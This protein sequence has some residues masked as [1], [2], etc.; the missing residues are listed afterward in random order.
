MDFHHKQITGFLKTKTNLY[1]EK[2]CAATMK[3][4]QQ[5]TELVFGFEINALNVLVLTA[6]QRGQAQYLVHVTKVFFFFTVSV[7][8]Y[9]INYNKHLVY[10]IQAIYMEF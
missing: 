10:L 6:F 7:K 1:R 5:Y 4:R 2:C 9:V 3:R 8:H